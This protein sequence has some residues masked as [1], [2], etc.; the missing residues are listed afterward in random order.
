MSYATAPTFEGNSLGVRR[1]R[2]LAGAGIM[3]GGLG[4]ISSTMSS[5]AVASGYAQSD[6]DLLNSVGAT[7]QDI[8]NLMSG[9][10]TLSQLYASY[11]VT[12]PGA[13]S[14]I[15]PAVPP[16]PPNYVQTALT[17]NPVSPSPA[18]VPQSS[19]GSTLLYTASFN[20]VPAFSTA[21]AVIQKIAAQLPTYRM[22]LVSQNILASG[23]TSAASFQITILDSVGHNYLSD[24]QSVLDSLL[25]AATGNG[26]I[27]SQITLLSAGGTSP[28]GMTPGITPGI[29]PVVPS[30]ATTWIQ[31]NWPVLA[32][33]SLAAM[34]FIGI[35]AEKRL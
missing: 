31:Q 27:S 10:V 6:L 13:G 33:G 32:V 24:A 18:S 3:L 14:G 8:A 25:Q 20:P 16:A 21:S 15:N 34:L 9:I 35:F 5:M 22:A 19:P 11:G 30:A 1:L 4:A 17:P 12:I 2:T 29:A 7:D 23:L 26:K 28:V